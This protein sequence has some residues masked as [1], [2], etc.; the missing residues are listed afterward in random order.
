MQ[1]KLSDFDAHLLSG[2]LEDNGWDAL[3]DSL[4]S[5]C[6]QRAQAIGRADFGT[7]KEKE[8]LSWFNRYHVARRARTMRVAGF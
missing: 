1:G 3:L 8:R 7:A 2:L 5:A 4:A 6:E